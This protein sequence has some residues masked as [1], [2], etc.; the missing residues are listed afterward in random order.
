MKYAIVLLLAGCAIAPVP[1]AR[2]F[3]ARQIAQT[4]RQ[5]LGLPLPAGAV[6]Y[7]FS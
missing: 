2:R 4:E 1:P 3:A 7:Y 6:A 5:A